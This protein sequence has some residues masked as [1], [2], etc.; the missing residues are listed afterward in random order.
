MN[1]SILS[2][3]K[4]KEQKVTPTHSPKQLSTI[5]PLNNGDHD[6]RGMNQHL[7][8]MRETQLQ[9]IL[10]FLS[11]YQLHSM[12]GSHLYLFFSSSYPPFN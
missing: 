5:V 6:R 3:S 7:S 9:L 12:S 10:P 4:E 2:W 8:Q 11:R 1:E